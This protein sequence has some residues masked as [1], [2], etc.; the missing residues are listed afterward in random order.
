[1][2]DVLVTTPYWGLLTELGMWT[3]KA[4]VEYKRMILYHNIINSEDG[5][6]SK[7]VIEEQKRIAMER[8]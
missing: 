8:G 1:M 5:R 6:L 3:A 7:M 4:T 2:M